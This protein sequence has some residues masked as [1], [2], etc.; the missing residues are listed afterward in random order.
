MAFA[1]FNLCRL[2][3][4]WMFY[5]LFERRRSR[6]GRW[7]IGLE[8]VGVIVFWCWFGGI[9]LRGCGSWKMALAYVLVSHAATSPLHVQA[10]RI[11]A[12]KFAQYTDEYCRLF[13][14]ISE[15]PRK[16]LGQWSH[17]P[18]DNFAPQWTSSARS[19]GASFMEDCNYKSHIICF[20]VSLDTISRK[21][22]LWSKSLP[23]RR[24]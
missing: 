1:R 11:L 17:S 10:R 5:K 9:V 18:V 6:G 14:P 20:L 7:A 4:S 21:Q 23:R 22:V 2:S 24:D 19:N 13:C 16:T 8:F 3:Y 12:I 15:C